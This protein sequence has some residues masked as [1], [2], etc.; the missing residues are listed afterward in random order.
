MKKKLKRE[1]T[2]EECQVES[3]DGINERSRRLCMKGF[4]EQMGF[5]SE[6]KY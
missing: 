6:G 1:K 3:V 4:V 2:D 5:K